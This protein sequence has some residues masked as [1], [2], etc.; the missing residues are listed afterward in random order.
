MTHDRPVQAAPTSGR[1]GT[2]EVWQS[3]LRFRRTTRESSV[4]SGAPAGYPTTTGAP[5]KSRPALCRGSPP[6][7]V[8][9]HESTMPATRQAQDLDLF[10][11]NVSPSIA[12]QSP[13]EGGSRDT[14]SPLSDGPLQRALSTAE[15]G[16]SRCRAAGP[17]PGG[18]V[19]QLRAGEA[20]AAASDSRGRARDPAGGGQWACVASQLEPCYCRGLS[21]GHAPGA[22]AAT[23]RAAFDRLARPGPDR[24]LTGAELN[25][26]AG[27]WAGRRPLA[28][29]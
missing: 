20:R 14:A 11:A 22:A 12:R 4:D 17:T 2:K 13:S 16:G 23:P 8:H 7:P 15:C 3:S 5:A 19:L 9:V 29:C 28:T 6:A 10:G 25:A 1:V 21:A 27:D 24:E 26:H 18:G